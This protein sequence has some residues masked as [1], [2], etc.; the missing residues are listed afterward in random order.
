MASS[1]S[2]KHSV[3]IAVGDEL[4]RGHTLDSNTNWL[5]QRLYTLGFPVR[6]VHIVS[7]VQDEIVAAVRG[8][9]TLEPTCLFLCGCLGPTPDDRT[10]AAL[11]VA[12]A[13]PLGLDARGAAHIQGPLDWVPAIGRTQSPESKH[14]NPKIPPSPPSASL[15]PHH[16]PQSPP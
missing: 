12:L 1:S 10:L 3:V 7:D 13:R 16:H 6:R 4:L 2:P 8:E 11:A 15:P 14:S 9:M 5:A